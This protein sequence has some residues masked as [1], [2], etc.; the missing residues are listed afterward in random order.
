MRET[1]LVDDADEIRRMAAGR[2]RCED[3]CRAASS[4]FD[5]LDPIR[6][7]LAP[8]HL[9]PGGWKAGCYDD[10]MKMANSPEHA[11]EVVLFGFKFLTTHDTLWRECRAF[12]NRAQQC[13][14]IV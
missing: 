1:I 11:E 13:R 5:G 10:E 8:G 9:M 7:R 14:E 12:K 2:Y 4:G 3:A 6:T